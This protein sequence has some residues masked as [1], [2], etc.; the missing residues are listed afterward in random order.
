MIE[1]KLICAI[2]E[3]D[4][5]AFRVLYE[6]YFYKVIN[7]SC[8]LLHSKEDAREVAQDVFVKLWNK[9]EYLD[10]AQSASGLIFRMTK[11]LSI[12]RIRKYQNAFPTIALSDASDIAEP[13]FETAYLYEELHSAYDKIIAKLPQKRRI[14]FQ[15]SRNENLS[16]KEI[17]E[18]LNISTKTV[19]AQIR[20]ALQQIREDI[21]RY[22]EALVILLIVLFSI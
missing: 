21:N 18:K 14:I 11:F 4:E 10:P 12:D 22:S 6:S 16:Y 3:G 5:K 13:S 9:R 8:K 15:L 20:L 2:K 17:A 1:G 7:Y 19:E